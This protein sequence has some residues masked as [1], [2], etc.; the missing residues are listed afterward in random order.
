MQSS[1]VPAAAGGP[2]TSIHRMPRYVAAGAAL[3]GA[4]LIVANPATQSAP[5]I[6]QHAVQLVDLD[7]TAGWSTVISEAFTNLQGIGNEIA[8]DPTPVLSQVIEN[9]AAFAATFSGDL[10]TIGTTLETFVSQDLPPALQAL[11]TGIDSGD[12]SNAVNDFNTAL[13]LGLIGVAQPIQDILSLPGEMSQNLTNVI[14]TLPNLGLNLLLSPLGPLDGTL[15]AIADS[16]QG[17]YDAV[18]AGDSTTVLTDLLN[19]PAFVTGAL[20]NGYNAEALGI[21]YTGLLSPESVPGFDFTGGLLD[22]LLVG[23]P[24]T[25]AQALGESTASAAGAAVDP[26]AFGDFGTQ[27][28][29][30]FSGI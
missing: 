29:D 1:P 17:I 25:I 19:M 10:Q 24:Q 3:I 15:Q 18:Q 8:A 26:G 13:L 16:S 28:L 23:L 7:V 21:D 20:L 5:A 12:I 4:G 9:Q 2:P 27:L 6:E 30:L 22:S 11:I 14:D